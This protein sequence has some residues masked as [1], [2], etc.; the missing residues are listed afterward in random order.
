METSKLDMDQ[1]MEQEHIVDI[2]KVSI[3]TKIEVSLFIFSSFLNTYI[4]YEFLVY[5]IIHTH[6]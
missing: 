6:S 1:E 3:I 4:T 2:D 5:F